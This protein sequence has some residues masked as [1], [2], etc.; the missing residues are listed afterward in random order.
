M[1][2]IVLCRWM[3]PK[4]CTFYKMSSSE[5]SK[6]RSSRHG[7]VYDKYKVIVYKSKLAFISIWH[8]VGNGVLYLVGYH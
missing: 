4:E 5:F 7:K 3:M 6:F 8:N 1:T 2:K